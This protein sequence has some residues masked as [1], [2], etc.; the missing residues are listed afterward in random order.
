MGDMRV[1]GG[2]AQGFGEHAGRDFEIGGHSGLG[3][4]Y[5]AL[6]DWSRKNGSLNMNCRA[7][8]SLAAI[9]VVQQR[10]EP[11]SDLGMAAKA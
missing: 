10:R 9:Q 8:H 1:A 7:A 2:K 3:R 6:L 11:W 5:A 4:E